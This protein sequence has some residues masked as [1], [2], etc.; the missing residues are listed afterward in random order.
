MDSRLPTFND[1]P[2]LSWKST[3]KNIINNIQGDESKKMDLLLKYTGSQSQIHVQSIR[4]SNSSDNVKELKLIWSR[5]E[6]MYGSREFIDHALKFRLYSFSKL[7]NKD[8][9]II[10]ELANSL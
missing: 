5:L 9:Q 6:K 4:T 1:K 10:Y 3:S 2:K 7:I 8:N